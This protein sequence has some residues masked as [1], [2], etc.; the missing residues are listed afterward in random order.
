MNRIKNI[1]SDFQGGLYI[2]EGDRSSL[3]ADL[4]S[5]YPFKKRGY[6]FNLKGARTARIHLDNKVIPACIDVAVVMII[7]CV[8]L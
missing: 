5:A 1:L 3:R 4:H 7:R 8:K 6:K 2:P